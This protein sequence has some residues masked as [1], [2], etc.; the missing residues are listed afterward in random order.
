LYKEEQRKITI[1]LSEIMK[2]KIQW[3]DIFKMLKEKSQPS[4]KK[5]IQKTK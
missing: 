5:I 1:A 2:D 3:D 4:Q